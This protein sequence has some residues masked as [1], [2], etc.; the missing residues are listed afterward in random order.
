[1]DVEV[2]KKIIDKNKWKT[3]LGN[4]GDILWTSNF[5]LIFKSLKHHFP[6]RTDLWKLAY[7]KNT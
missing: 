7:F 3:A 5:Y 4:E 1:M 6:N 2:V